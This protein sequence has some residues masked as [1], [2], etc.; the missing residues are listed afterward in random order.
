M[1]QIQCKKITCKLFNDISNSYYTLWFE[2]GI[3]PNNYFLNLFSAGLFLVSMYHPTLQK[4]V[5]GL[6]LPSLLSHFSL[7]VEFSM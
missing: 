6:D 7:L 4:P 2:E 5:Q 1:G 3:L